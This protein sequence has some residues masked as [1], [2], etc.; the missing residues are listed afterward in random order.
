MSLPNGTKVISVTNENEPIIVGTI[1][2]DARGT[3]K[4]PNFIPLIACGGKELYSFGVTMPY[5]DTLLEK[6][7]AITDYMERWEFAVE[8][9]QKHFPNVKK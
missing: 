1:V 3:I 8:Y 6:L 4:S 9:Q 7:E 5:S 2:R